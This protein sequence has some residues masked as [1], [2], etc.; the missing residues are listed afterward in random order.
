MMLR[1]DGVV[2][3]IET[4]SGNMTYQYAAI[5]LSNTTIIL[6]D[7]LNAAGVLTLEKLQDPVVNS[8]TNN[9]R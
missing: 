5:Y 7:P 8:R 3:W 1:T 2:N 6:P 4:S 9:R